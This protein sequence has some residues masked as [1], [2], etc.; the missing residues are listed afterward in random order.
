[1]SIKKLFVIFAILKDYH[2]ISKGYEQSMMVCISDFINKLINKIDSDQY[3]I[4]DQ[5]RQGRFTKHYQ[6]YHQR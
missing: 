3:C 5:K 6:Y 4:Q 1:M 2:E